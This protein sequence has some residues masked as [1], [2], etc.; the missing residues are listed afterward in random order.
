MS[1]PQVP[2]DDTVDRL[3]GDGETYDEEKEIET[4]K[5]L[6]LIMQL[7]T[8]TYTQSDNCIE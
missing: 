5:K 4:A 1:I 3:T 6:G 8:G 7:P 2:I